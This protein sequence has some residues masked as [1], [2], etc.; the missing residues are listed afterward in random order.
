MR[1]FFFLGKNKENV[2]TSFVTFAESN[3][4]TFSAVSNRSIPIPITLWS[5]NSS[6][7]FRQPVS[8]SITISITHGT[9]CVF[10]GC[11]ATD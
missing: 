10:R 1:A 6:V 9:R 8:I 3:A 2:V 5:G 7:R 11:E 4:G